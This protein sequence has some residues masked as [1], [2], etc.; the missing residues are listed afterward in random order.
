MPSR[1]KSVILIR[2]SESHNTPATINTYD[3]GPLRTM[4]S[5]PLPHISKPS[6]NWV[7]LRPEVPPDALTLDQRAT[8]PINHLI[9]VM[10]HWINKEGKGVLANSISI[11]TRGYKGPM[12]SNL[13]AWSWLVAHPVAHPVA[14]LADSVK[15]KHQRTSSKMMTKSRKLRQK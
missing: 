11:S 14:H 12:L 4:S 15:T 9:A 1:S 5:P 10:R 6:L 8:V 7:L 2:W 3:S 13:K